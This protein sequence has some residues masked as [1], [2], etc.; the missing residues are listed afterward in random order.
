MSSEYHIELHKELKKFLVG[1]KIGTSQ[2]TGVIEGTVYV[3][4][5]FHEGFYA[6]VKLDKT[7][8]RKYFNLGKKRITLTDC[9]HL[10]EISGP[11]GESL[12]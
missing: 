7:G 8:E 5:G 4:S 1:N 6:R 3:P 10:P 9:E 2:G 12:V 11:S